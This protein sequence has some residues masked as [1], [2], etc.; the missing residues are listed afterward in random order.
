[1]T[2]NT[3]HHLKFLLS[4]EFLL[5]MLSIVNWKILINNWSYCKQMVLLKFFLDNCE[6]L[7]TAH[8]KMEL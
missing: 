3:K 2:L 8:V 5:L 6:T 1:M 7:F 4:S